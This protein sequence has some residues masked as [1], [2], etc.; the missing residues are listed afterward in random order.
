D[1]SAMMTKALR[2]IFFGWKVVAAGF[3]VSAFTFGV[4]YYGPSVFLNV[5]HQQRGWPVSLVSSA[6]TVH[7]LVS[8]VLVTGLPAAHHRFG[9]APITMLG[10]VVLAVGMLGWSIALVPWHLFAA[11]TISGAGWAATN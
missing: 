4:G 9:I 2:P 7:F 3:T 1:G 10:I 11:A 8:A 6:I 5:L